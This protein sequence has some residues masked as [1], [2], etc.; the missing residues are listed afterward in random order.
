MVRKSKKNMLFN[1]FLV[2]LFSLVLQMIAKMSY[3]MR[4]GASFHREVKPTWYGWLSSCDKNPNIKGCN[5][6]KNDAIHWAMN[7]GY[8][9]EKSCMQKGLDCSEIIEMKKKE[10]SSEFDRQMKEAEDAIKKQPIFTETESS[11]FTVW[12]K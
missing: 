11:L 8:N 2:F 10:D 7:N 5:D 4:E 9:W 1:L 3:N 6:L 12:Q